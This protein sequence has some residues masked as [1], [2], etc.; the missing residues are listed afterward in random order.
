MASGVSHHLGHTIMKSIIALLLSTAA[1]GLSSWGSPSATEAN[2][3]DYWSGWRARQRAELT[4]L[5]KPTEPP[6]GAGSPVDRFLAAD[7]TKAKPSPP[8]PTDDAAFARRVY[9]D[10]IGLLP[11]TE[12]LDQFI[13]D[14][15]PDKRTRLVDALLADKQ[16]YA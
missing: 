15:R 11:T 8:D 9:I 6:D 3:D 10:V 16:G 5:P 12:Q 4:A 1:M 13:N 14:A 2:P 7:W